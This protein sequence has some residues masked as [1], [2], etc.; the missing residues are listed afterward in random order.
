MNIMNEKIKVIAVTG[1]TAGG[2]S[3]LALALAKELD[4]EIVSLDSMQI[5]RGMDIGTAKPSKEEQRAVRHHLIDIL[6]PDECFSAAEYATLAEKAIEDIVT[7][8]KTP[9]VCGGTGLYL[10]ALRTARHGESMATDE[11][12]RAEM[13]ALAEREGNDALHARLREIDPESADAIH[14]NNVTRV[15]RAL[16]IYHLTGKPKSVFDREAPRENPRLSVLNLTLTYLSRELLYNRIDA[17]VEIM[18]REG[19]LEE[20][21]RLLSAGALKKGSTASAA[22]GY[23]ECLGALSGE[24]TEREAAQALC[25]A[26]RHYAK[27]QITW[28]SA[29]EHTPIYA[30]TEGAMRP[31]ED[32]LDEAL[33]AAREF[34]NN[35][36]KGRT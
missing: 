32:V 30:D 20:T 35:G 13:R 22:I 25:L 3:A 10:E 27:R 14:K 6:D 33:V 12:F 28:F 24:M 31:F 26:T 11:A 21:K 36:Q 17:R 29:K 5:Y 4:G 18:M 23:K 16:E 1:P 9:I 7:R 8:G 15:I 2:K 34:L 19:L